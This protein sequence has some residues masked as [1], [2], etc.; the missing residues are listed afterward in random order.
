MALRR[1]R[2]GILPTRRRGTAVALS[3]LAMWLVAADP[4]TAEAADCAAKGPR[5][6]QHPLN[7]RQCLRC[8]AGNVA[9]ATR[10]KCVPPPAPR[11]DCAFYGPDFVV[12]PWNASECRRCP[13]GTLADDAQRACVPTQIVPPPPDPS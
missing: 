10:T 3:L 13:A 6:I 8:E 1:W 4:P 2:A 5:F 9:D 7:P 12:A 11:A